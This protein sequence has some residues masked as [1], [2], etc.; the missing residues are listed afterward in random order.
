MSIRCASRRKVRDIYVFG[1]NLILLAAPLFVFLYNIPNSLISAPIALLLVFAIAEI[2]A[3]FRIF[4]MGARTLTDSAS[5]AFMSLL[6]DEAGIMAI[7]KYSAVGKGAVY[8]VSSA[9]EATAFTL[10][11]F[12]P[13]LI[14]TGRLCIAASTA[15]DQ[16]RMIIRHELSHCDNNDSWLWQALVMTFVTTLPSLLLGSDAYGL[17]GREAVIR[18]ILTLPAGIF[19]LLYCF[20]RREYIADAVALNHTESRNDY[21]GLLKGAGRH[22]KSWFHP[23]PEDRIAA[24]DSDCPVLRIDAVLLYVMLTTFAGVID[25]GIANL[26][27]SENGSGTLALGMFALTL[28]MGIALVAEMIKGFS[29]KIPLTHTETHAR[30]EPRTKF[31]SA[32]A[33]AV[34]LGQERPNLIRMGAFV[35]AQLSG[36]LIWAIT[37]YY[38]YPDLRAEGHIPSVILESLR[39]TLGWTVLLL[40]LLRFRRSV[41]EVGIGMALAAVTFSVLRNWGEGLR[42][43]AAEITGKI[44]EFWENALSVILL[45][46][47]VARFKKPFVGFFVGG[48]L[49]FLFNWTLHYA[50]SVLSQD[51]ELWALEWGIS[52]HREV[53]EIS[54]QVLCEVIAATIMMLAI[55]ITGGKVSDDMSM[56]A[57][58]TD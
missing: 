24:M 53:K 30:F 3:Q 52:V 35:L 26:R 45:G 54:V 42:L 20:R 56:P 31:L 50:L 25:L 17:E 16:V 23:M 29:R 32:L 40:L 28:L 21:I 58:P 37:S 5:P 41:I 1:D 6:R 9:V 43:S 34:G 22:R 12:T 2:Y 38:S 11:G 39:W 55:M 36:W 27:D 48:L 33:K 57:Q 51:R 14:V 4:R 15:P 13:K 47:A 46:Y 8:Y 18:N 7:P 49:S 19:L 10:G 44:A